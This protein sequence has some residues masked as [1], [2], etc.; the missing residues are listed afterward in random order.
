MIIY[1]RVSF[2]H[3]VVLK[4]I[5]KKRSEKLTA[6]AIISTFKKRYR[7]LK[8]SKAYDMHSKLAT[9]LYSG[10]SQT[11]LTKLVNEVE[12][13]S[14]LNSHYNMQG[15]LAIQLYIGLWPVKGCG[16]FEHHYSMHEDREI[17]RQTFELIYSPDDTNALSGDATK[18][19]ATEPNSNV[20][21]QIIES[22]HQMLLPMTN[23]VVKYLE[24]SL[25]CIVSHIVFKFVF[26]R[27][28]A[29]FLT[30]IRGVCLINVP[31]EITANREVFFFSQMLQ[32]R[33]EKDSSV[34]GFPNK[35]NDD[36]LTGRRV[37]MARQ[38]F[39]AHD[40]MHSKDS[41]VKIVDAKG[42]IEDLAAVDRIISR[43]LSPTLKPVSFAMPD[44]ST[45]AHP[46]R[47]TDANVPGASTSLGNPL[48]GHFEAALSAAPL[49]YGVAQYI[50][51]GPGG[52][53]MAR[54]WSPIARS[55]HYLSKV[56]LLIL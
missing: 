16:M 54:K 21:V 18:P 36:P 28:W 23:R 2:I 46:I 42:Q 47:P 53:P 13:K 30:G 26:N 20:Q 3:G 17:S 45:F 51:S 35:S 29:P 33:T 25:S 31:P 32:D 7:A 49:P 10:G 48:A 1:C 27:L 14:I 44:T 38:P 11:I 55:A 22:Q 15:I 56:I 24:T 12:L 9:L 6:A 37:E 8:G 39:V 43:G 40:R 41:V 5:L 19:V 52:Q 50:Q 34:K 4:E